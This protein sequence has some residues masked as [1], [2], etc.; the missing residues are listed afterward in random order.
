M[1]DK[2]AGIF[3]TDGIGWLSPDGEFEPCTTY[4]HTAKAAEICDRFQNSGYVKNFDSAIMS[5][6]WIKITMTRFLDYGYRFFGRRLGITEEQKNILREFY[7]KRREKIAKGGFDDL[8][9]FCV[10]DAFEWTKGKY[11]ERGAE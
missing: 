8:F 5:R 6:G 4:E 1:E 7:E 3:E 2:T 9:E 11:G 10:I